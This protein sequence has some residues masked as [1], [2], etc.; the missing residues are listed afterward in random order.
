MKQL[1]VLQLSFPGIV[2]FVFVTFSAVQVFQNI[3][4]A[5]V[6]PIQQQCPSGQVP[7]MQNGQPVINPQTGYPQCKP[8]DAFGNVFGQ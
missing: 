6:V 3:A 7:V 8:I 5:Q 2:L 1:A 4:H